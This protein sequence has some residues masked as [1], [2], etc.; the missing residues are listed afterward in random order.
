[1]TSL[2]TG[3]TSFRTIIP[4][5]S[6][7]SGLL[8]AAVDAHVRGDATLAA[9]LIRQADMPELRE[10]LDSIWGKGSPHI[11]HRSVPGSPVFCARVDRMARRMPDTEAK[12][13]LVR[14]DG[15]HCRLCGMPV[16]R[17]EIR[18]HLRLTYPDVLPWGRRNVEQHV[19][20]QVMWLQYDHVIP[21]ARGGTNELDNML[22][23]CAACNF[24][25]MNYT[26]EEVGFSSLREI[27]LTTSDWDG[28]EKVLPIAQRLKLVPAGAG[29][30]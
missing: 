21:H 24:G 12:R 22:V 11:H 9:A 27:R 10:W 25:R 23:A 2:P 28:L 30:W 17:A 26:L 20:F 14:R 18:Q 3:R 5:I 16:I 8:G 15:H 7:A 19:A 29:V 1:M 4:E 6:T 13:A